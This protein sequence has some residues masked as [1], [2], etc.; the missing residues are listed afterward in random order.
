[1]KEQIRFFWN[2]F[3][4]IGKKSNSMHQFPNIF[5]NGLTP[6]QTVPNIEF[7]FWYFMNM[8]VPIFLSEFKK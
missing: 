8:S 3:A 5:C 2:I 6:E 4:K 1:M 7:V